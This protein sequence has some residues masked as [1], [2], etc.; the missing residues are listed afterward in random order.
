MDDDEP[1]GQGPGEPD[2]ASRL[3]ASPARDAFGSRRTSAARRDRARTARC[4]GDAR[5]AGR[6]DARLPADTDHRLSD[7]AAALVARGLA[8]NTRAAYERHWA[9]FQRWCRLRGRTSLPA[10][11]ETL[12]EYVHHLTETTTQYGGPPSP[13]TINHVLGCL[14]AAHKHTGQICD[15]R[16]ARLA[17]RAYRREATPA[18]PATVR[19]RRARPQSLPIALATLRTLVY[20]I[21][22]DVGAGDLEP[23][24]GQ[25]DQVALVL[26]FAMAS[27]A[28]EVATLDIAD[29]A[30]SDRG[31]TVTVRASKT[32]QDARG[33]KVHLKYGR[34]LETCPVR[35]TQ[36]WIATLAA[37]EVTSGRLLR[38][39]DRSGRLAG[40]PGYAGRTRGDGTPAPMSNDALNTLLR[41]AVRAG[42]GHRPRRRCSKNPIATP[43]TDCAPGSRHPP[44]R[45]A[46]HPAPSPTTAGGRACSWSCTTGAAEPPGPTTPWTRSTC[47]RRTRAGAAA[48]TRSEAQ[49]PADQSEPS[50]GMLIDT[51]PVA[52]LGDHDEG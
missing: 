47:S 18:T 28:L 51:G 19:G 26:G 29:L 40:T 36:A 30:F 21:L 48:H 44:P 33:A 16:L 38:G 3:P 37:N 8:S 1:T 12:A 2:A 39:I 49:G 52:G 9:P 41:A 45:A 34:H 35:L 46:R 31:L 27:R 11:A 17:L 20:A 7:K 4:G 23:V 43:G 24:R 22:A 25:R 32:D 50:S 14:Q 6:G 15:V 42:A 10:T 13:S 5:R